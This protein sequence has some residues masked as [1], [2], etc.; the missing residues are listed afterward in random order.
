VNN[1]FSD[2]VKSIFMEMKVPNGK[3]E[4]TMGSANCIIKMYWTLTRLFDPNGSY[5]KNWKNTQY[6]GASRT[7]LV[8]FNNSLQIAIRVTGVSSDKRFRV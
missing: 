1:D 6:P 7:A 5:H 8:S 4:H 2:E 3:W